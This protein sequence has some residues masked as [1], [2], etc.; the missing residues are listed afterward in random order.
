M[1]LILIYW[2]IKI[3]FNYKMTLYIACFFNVCIVL[4]SM[5]LTF[6]YCNYWCKE[7]VYGKSGVISSNTIQLIYDLNVQCPDKYI[8]SCILLSALLTPNFLYCGIK[9]FFIFT[10]ITIQSNF[11]LYA[12]KFWDLCWITFT[13]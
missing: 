10:W 4:F 5:C 8:V 3:L 1:T 12:W 7:Y 11:L 13:P 9:F 2:K 6:N